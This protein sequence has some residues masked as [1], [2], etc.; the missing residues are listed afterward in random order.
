MPAA[1]AQSECTLTEKLGAQGFS[2][3][4]ADERD[5][6]QELNLLLQEAERRK[7]LEEEAEKVAERKRQKLKEFQELGLRQATDRAESPQR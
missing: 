7:A 6:K 1:H 4:L 2:K 3:L 5:P